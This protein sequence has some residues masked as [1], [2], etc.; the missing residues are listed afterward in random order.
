[1]PT[2]PCIYDFK[3]ANLIYCSLYFESTH[4]LQNRKIEATCTNEHFKVFDNLINVC[5]SL[6]RLNLSYNQLKNLTGLEDLHGVNYSL[7]ILELHGNQI[8]QLVPACQSL[9]GCSNL[10]HVI[11]SRAGSENPICLLS[12]L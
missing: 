3:Y 9:K 2:C 8:S 6:E 7:T 1:M 11:F 12:G 4:F 5:S 10:R